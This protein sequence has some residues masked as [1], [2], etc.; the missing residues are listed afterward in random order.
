MSSDLTSLQFGT[1]H[2]LPEGGFAEPHGLQKASTGSS[3]PIPS[4]MADFWNGTPRSTVLTRDFLFVVP[5]LE[6]QMAEYERQMQSGHPPLGVVPWLRTPAHEICTAG[7]RPT[8]QRGSDDVDQFEVEQ[9]NGQPTA[10]G[11]WA[12]TVLTQMPSSELAR[13]TAEDLNAEVFATTTSAHA[14]TLFELLLQFSPSSIIQLSENVL[15]QKYDGNDI[16][17]VNK[18]MTFADKYL[19]SRAEYRNSHGG[20]NPPD[21]LPRPPGDVAPSF[22]GPLGP[23]PATPRR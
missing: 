16:S 17:A 4:G 8:G 5:N 18:G 15:T 1:S 23:K 14:A 21:R 20:N 2:W 9:Q 6:E 12:L 22:L 11:W 3:S 7:L 13:L 19:E 10:D